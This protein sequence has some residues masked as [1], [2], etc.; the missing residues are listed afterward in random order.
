[1]RPALPP[2]LPPPPPTNPPTPAPSK[3]V[4]DLF[5]IVCGTSTGGILAALFAVKRTRVQEAARLYDELLKKVFY[6]VRE[7]GEGGG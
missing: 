5:D 1:L 6:K 3:Q 7:R 2:S 4:H